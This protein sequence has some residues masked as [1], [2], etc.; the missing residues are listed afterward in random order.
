MAVILVT[1][2]SG[3]G[4]STVLIAL[5]QRGYRVVDTDYRGW[6]EAIPHPDGSEPQWRADR[7]EPLLR[8]A[9]TTEI[10]TRNPPTE[11]ADQLAALAGPPGVP[12]WQRRVFNCRAFVVS[13]RMGSIP[14][15]WRRSAACARRGIATAAALPR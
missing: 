10:D 9:A 5:G 14:D 13:I 15:G 7:I 12:D 4:K 8:S 3:T 11:V 2:M 1:G 6:I